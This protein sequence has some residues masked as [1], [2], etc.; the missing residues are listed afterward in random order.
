MEKEGPSHS[1][2]EVDK[3][4]TENVLMWQFI[5]KC[6]VVD[7]THLRDCFLS[8]CSAS[9]S[10][11]PLDGGRRKRFQSRAESVSF[12]SQLQLVLRSVLTGCSW[13][14]GCCSVYRVS[15]CFLSRGAVV[16]QEKHQ[17]ATQH[18]LGNGRQTRQED[19]IVVFGSFRRR[20]TLYQQGADN[21]SQWNVKLEESI[22][23]E[24]F[25]EYCSL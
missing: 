24:R 19:V 11:T 25:F 21:P 3:E 14:V 2:E 12:C 10:T 20:A 18:Y 9:T 13:R 4:C 15:C 5:V 8:C 22:D 16:V 23:K 17:P 1:P 7:P 6:F